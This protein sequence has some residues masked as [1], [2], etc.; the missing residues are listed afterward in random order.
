[1]S[2]VQV[3]RIIPIGE[4][5][6]YRSINDITPEHVAL[7][8]KTA[9]IL[10]PWLVGFDYILTHDL[11]FTGLLLPYSLAIRSVSDYCRDL[12]WYHWVHSNPFGHK[13][14]WD[15]SLYHG[16]HKL[17][18]PSKAG[19]T[20]VAKAFLAPEDLVLH[21]PHIKD[22]RD[23]LKF[24]QN[25]RAIIDLF[26]AI[27]QADIVQIFPAFTDRF[28]SKGVR[29]LIILF[30]LL[31]HRGKSVCLVIP[32]QFSD[33]R[34]G[35]IV[36]PVKYHEK[37]ARRNGL[38]PYEDFIFTSEI[39]GE[40]YIE[41]LP[42]QIVM[43][44]MA[45][46]NLFIFPSRSESFGFTSTEAVLSG[47]CLPVLNKSCATQMEVLGGHGIPFDFGNGITPVDSTE[48]E[49]KRFARLADEIVDRLD[50]NPAIAAR[51]YVR[52]NYNR[53]AIYEKYYR[54]I[55]TPY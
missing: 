14:W 33:R 37:I 32:N 44:L 15:I 51:T 45:C 46:G 48:P 42:H 22:I 55:L 21:I 11:L 4:L 28:E 49:S 40:K 24:S 18:F 1:M 23:E 3:K 7:S 31:K 16:N 26:P 5:R 2:G 8:T 30:G 36:D 27:L 19:I 43:D 41:G 13:D 54:N 17:V 20:Q 10:A 12:T 9:E 50:S 52:Q 25:T 29:D 38:R 39:L 47:S 35:R 53:N 6:D 34:S